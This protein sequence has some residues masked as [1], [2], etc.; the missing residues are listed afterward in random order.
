MPLGACAKAGGGASGSGIT[1]PPQ[2]EVD[3]VAQAYLTLLRGQPGVTAATL[4]KAADCT[5]IVSGDCSH[6][7]VA[8]HMRSNVMSLRSSESCRLGMNAFHPIALRKLPYLLLT[9]SASIPTTRPLANRA[10]PGR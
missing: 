7:V 3:A 10:K 4:V 8:L 2:A 5:W 9:A 1:C 6:Q